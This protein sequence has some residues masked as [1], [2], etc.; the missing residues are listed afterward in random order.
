MRDQAATDHTQRKKELAARKQVI[1]STGCFACAADEA[2]LPLPDWRCLT[3]AA[4]RMHQGCA[5]A[6]LPAMPRSL[7]LRCLIPAGTGAQGGHDQQRPGRV[8]RI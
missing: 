6:R 5:S 3:A 1:S 4:C 8:S 2:P 7:A